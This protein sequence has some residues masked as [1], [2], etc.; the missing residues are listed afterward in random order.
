MYLKSSFNYHGQCLGTV[1]LVAQTKMAPLRVLIFV[2]VR[3]EVI[4]TS[5]YPWQGHVIPLNHGRIATSFATL[6]VPA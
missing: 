2:F 4:E 6:L 1:L 5:T 3:P